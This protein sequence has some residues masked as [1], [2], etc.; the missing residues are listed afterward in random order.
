MKDYLVC[1]TAKVDV[2]MNYYEKLEFQLL[3]NATTKK[4][5]NAKQIMLKL[6]RVPEDVR[7]A[8]FKAFV[9]RCQ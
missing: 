6:K 2:L 8:M 4:D 1:R 9:Q 3:S 7:Y 5:E